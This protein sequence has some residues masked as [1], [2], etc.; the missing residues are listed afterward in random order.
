MRKLAFIRTSTPSPTKSSTS[1]RWRRLGTVRH[2][3]RIEP[4]A[5]ERLSTIIAMAMIVMEAYLPQRP[6]GPLPA[7]ARCFN[8][9]VLVIIIGACTVVNGAGAWWPSSAGAGGTVKDGGRD[10]GGTA[11][12]KFDDSGGGGGRR[13][14]R[15][16]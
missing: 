9:F 15:R 11:G 7:T 14:S 10:G 12:M 13:C 3:V 1:G 4:W 8:S 5:A 16:R 6:R 2:V